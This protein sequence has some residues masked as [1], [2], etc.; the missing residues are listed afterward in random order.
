MLE[1]PLLYLVTGR[2]ELDQQQFL[3]RIELACQGGVDLLQLRE[4]EI[5]SGEYYKLASHVKK[6]TDRYQVPL[7]I[8]DQVA[9]AQAVDAA[10]VHLGQ[11]DLPVA[12]AR[13]ILGPDKIIG[14]TTKTVAQAR[15][16]VEEGANYLGVGA[17]FPT[18]THVKTVHTSVATLKQIKQEAKITV[19]AIG[20]LNAENLSVLRN[21]NVD[22]V[23]VVSAIMKAPDIKQAIQHLRTALSDF[24]N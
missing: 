4:K 22:G 17:I 14:A 23:A 18:T 19:F 16:A 11:A 20:G 8:D 6:I 24:L 13:R 15:R 7:I 2:L 3:E 10:G 5:S 12:V 21:T 1:K 9:I